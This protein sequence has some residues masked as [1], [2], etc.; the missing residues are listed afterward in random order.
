MRLAILAFAAI[1]LAVPLSA[2]HN[3]DGCRVLTTSDLVELHAVSLA[4]LLERLPGLEV[5]RYN[6]SGSFTDIKQIGQELYDD[7]R[8]VVVTVNGV[9]L[10]NLST[11][12]VYLNGIAVSRIDSVTV[13]PCGGLSGSEVLIDVAL[14]DSFITPAHTR[15]LW[16]TG[17]FELGTILF[18]FRRALGEKSGL[19]VSMQKSY[20]FEGRGY[21]GNSARTPYEHPVAI[22]DI[23][24]V[25]LG[26]SENRYVRSGLPFENDTRLWNVGLT[27]RALPGTALTARYEYLRDFQDDYVPVSGATTGQF[28]NFAAWRS[29]DNF[30]LEGRSLTAGPLHLNGQAYLQRNTLRFADTGTPIGFRDTAAFGQSVNALGF[31]GRAGYERRFW[32]ARA[33]AE[34][35]S[36]DWQGRSYSAAFTRRRLTTEASAGPDSAAV[37]WR[38]TLRNTLRNDGRAASNGAV[39]TR[40]LASPSTAARVRLFDRLD[41]DA[42]YGCE[43][44]Y[45]LASALYFDNPRRDYLANDFNFRPIVSYHAQTGLRTRLASWTFGYSLENR[46]TRSPLVFVHIAGIPGWTVSQDSLCYESRNTHL[47]TTAY[48]G[49]RLSNTVAFAVTETRDGLPSRSL[50]FRTFG[51]MDRFSARRDFVKGRLHGRFSTYLYLRPQVWSVD[52]YGDIK[53]AILNEY[54]RVD[55]ELEFRIKDF[56]FYTRFENLGDYVI[57]YAPGY[58]LPGPLIRWGIDWTFGK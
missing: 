29:S 37:P 44:R 54:A 1:F 48:E 13:C 7:D 41:F 10:R 55:M 32:H 21:Y 3:A 4:D 52:Y 2:W 43:R 40:M 11:D 19:S 36:D 16:E 31:I 35:A 58:H 57:A 56:H 38:L 34:A 8:P 47:F 9:E 33:E 6:T 23:Y 25:A 28:R 45:P 49:T 30:Y 24:R 53:T 27:T 42:G 14:S 5:A 51:V 15:L 26:R 12:R 50:F 20:Q 17:P 46:F 22:T 18:D 39:N